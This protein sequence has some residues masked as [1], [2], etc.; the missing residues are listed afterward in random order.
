M[1]ILGSH[2]P[3][4]PEVGCGNLAFFTA[5]FLICSSG[6]WTCTADAATP[7]LKFALPWI[8]LA[9]SA[10]HIVTRTFTVEK[11]CKRRYGTAWDN[12]TGRVKYRL[13]PKVF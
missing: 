5:A 2:A 1:P 6:G 3:C 10:M 7:G 9:I 13:L 12:Y 8:I 4:G 11:N